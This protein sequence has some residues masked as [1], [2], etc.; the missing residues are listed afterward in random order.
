VVIAMSPD[1][2]DEETVSAAQAAR[3]R[4][5]HV[6]ALTRGGALAAAAHAGGWPSSDP[7]GGA[8]ALAS[9]GPMAVGLSAVLARL[10]LGPDF[11]AEVQGAAEALRAQQAD[12]RAE[13]PV[14]RNP[15]KRMAGQFMD[16]IPFIFAP[17]PL[18][19]VARHW[20]S[21]V[22]LMA[23]S[24]AM[25]DVV[26]EMDHH[27]IAGTL[28]PESLSTKYM[29]LALRTAF[30]HERDQWLADQTRTVYMTAGFNTDAVDGTGSSPLAHMLTALHYGDYAAFYLAMCY[31]ID[32]RI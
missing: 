24:P 28:H 21:Q 31:G 1:G 19:A 16:R 30:A 26:P 18:A 32:P 22:N 10:G 11:S 5:A 2:D 14:T 27:T 9:T 6:L 23:K 15:A 12:F 13:T 8:P 29:V 4:G 3:E 17:E 7:C 20:K 25:C